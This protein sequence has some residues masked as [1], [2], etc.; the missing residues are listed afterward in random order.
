MRIALVQ[1]T[2]SRSVEDNIG[3]VRARLAE[4][5]RRHADV[6]VFPEATMRAFGHSLTE[7]AEPLDGPWADAVRAAADDAG[8]VAV[9]GMFTPGEP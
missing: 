1:L 5:G 9:V 8:V 3:L 6:V 7:V 2:S 4:A